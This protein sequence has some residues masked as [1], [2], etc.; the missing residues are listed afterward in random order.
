MK[1]EVRDQGGVWKIADQ[2]ELEDSDIKE[3]NI[4]DEGGESNFKS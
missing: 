3:V 2:K 4:E 1:S